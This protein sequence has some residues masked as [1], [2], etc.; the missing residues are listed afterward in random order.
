[1]P[2]AAS[3][4]AGII[5]PPPWPTLLCIFSDGGASDGAGAGCCWVRWGREADPECAW[6]R[7]ATATWQLPR[8]MAPAEAELL[9]SLSSL[10]FLGAA[11]RE[12]VFGTGGGAPELGILQRAAWPRLLPGGIQVRR[13]PLRRPAQAAKGNPALC[14]S[15]E[16]DFSVSS[17]RARDDGLAVDE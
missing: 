6:Q 17:K 5:L 16:V 12:G 4:A 11:L 3:I 8:Q 14:R 7:L 9:G 13:M 15:R 1:M 10:Q 2:D